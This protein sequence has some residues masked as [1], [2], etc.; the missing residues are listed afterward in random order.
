MIK[1]IYLDYNATTPVD[2]KVL[3][4]MLP[5]FTE[6]FG[7]PS[8]ANHS[9]G[10]TAE[11]AVKKSREQV[12][13]LLNC[14]PQELFFTSGASESNNWMLFGL[15]S[16]LKQEN[17]NEKIHILTSRAE[18]SSIINS[19]KAAQELG[20]EVEFLP[21]NSYGQVELETIKKSIKSHTKLISVIWI[22]N[23]IGTINPI[24][25]I[26]EVAHANK[27]Y[28]HTDATQA[29]GK[30]P[31]NLKQLKIDLLSFSGHKLYGPKGIGALFIRHSNPFVEI[32]PLI[33][34]GGQEQGQR[35][36][37]L[38]VPGIV[39]LGEAC[40]ICKNEMSFES[41]R[42][43]KLHDYLTE[44]ILSEIPGCQINGHPSERATNCISA[45]FNQTSIDLVLPKLSTLGISMSAACGSGRT[46]ISHVLQAIG[47]TE[48]QANS[49]IRISLGRWTSEDEIKETFSILKAAFT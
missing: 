27:I 22:N 11:S 47:L 43:K 28:F 29:V 23:E 39:G 6:N 36:G 45:T 35:S 1:K 44:R 30:L 19:M 15:V 40:E 2:P 9:W 42:I 38:N 46:H 41:I 33:Y 37:T 5:Y 26:G 49:T 31:I 17:P 12:A 10:W 13:S 14:R 25:E 32:N 24:Q 34:G 8:S 20:V 4:K 18:H 3:D 16:K 48:L 7:N 21:V